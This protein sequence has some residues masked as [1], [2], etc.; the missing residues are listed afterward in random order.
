MYTLNLRK[1]IKSKTP[2]MYQYFMKIEQRKTID[3]NVAVYFY[4]TNK[5]TLN[6]FYKQISF[7]SIK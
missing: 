2:L 4:Q 1:K 7:F 3:E 5:F 6:K